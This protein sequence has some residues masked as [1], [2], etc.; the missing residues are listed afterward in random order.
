VRTIRLAETPW[1]TTF[2]G[3]AL[4]L[5]A[6]AAAD[7]VGAAP[8]LAGLVTLTL[9]LALVAGFVVAPH[10]VLAG[11]IPLFAVL[12]ALKVLVAPEL[13]P[14]KDLAVLACAAGA[15][16]AALLRARTGAP[17]RADPA[18]LALVVA[19]GALYVVNPGGLIAGTGFDVAWL[20]GVR[21][22]G[23]P[24]AL[25]LIGLTVADARRTARWAVASLVATGVLVA[26]VGIVQQFLGDVR[27][28]DLGY[29]YEHHL[30]TIDGRLRS[31]GTMDDPFTYAGFLLLALAACLFAVRRPAV[32]VAAG[33][34]VALGL[35]VSYVRTAAVVAVALG[36]IWLARHRL[37]VPAVL[38]VTAAFV[39]AA[40][41]LAGQTG[42]TQ[43]TVQRGGSVVLALNGRAEAWEVALGPPSTWPFGRGVGE[44][45]TAAERATFTIAETPELETTAVAVDSGYFATIADVGLI[46]L[47]LLVALLVRLGTLALRDAARDD[48][49]G[50]LALGVLTVLAL[51]AVTRSSFTGFPTAFLGFLLVGLALAAARA[52]DA[53]RS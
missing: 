31:F 42:T 20:Q 40:V 45:G 17:R 12:P 44:V 15:A 39:T 35:A 33:S 19:L 23:E 13:G 36:G 2:A 51:D 25:L 10:V 26:G 38:V 41:L 47:A 9:F 48:D 1:L 4:T 32:A 16:L 5:A 8:S 3:A 34:V 46:G 14:A 27:L 22:V 7:R 49:F 28:Y 30:R 24:L 53:R 21:L 43:H 50:W 52:P 11:L 37:V 18:V 6:V 29:E